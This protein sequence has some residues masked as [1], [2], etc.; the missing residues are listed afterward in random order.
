MRRPGRACSPVALG[1]TGSLGSLTHSIYPIATGWVQIDS[2]AITD[3]SGLG[4]RRAAPDR[5]CL[6]D[7]P[8]PGSSLR[9]C[10]RSSPQRV[11]QHQGAQSVTDTL[12]GG[13]SSPLQ[14]CP[15]SVQE[16]QRLPV[17]LVVI[18]EHRC[19]ESRSARPDHR[20]GMLVSRESPLAQS[21]DACSKLRR[22]TASAN[23]R[24]CRRRDCS[25]NP[26][27]T[28][29]M[30]P[31]TS[32]INSRSIPR[33]VRI[34]SQIFAIAPHLPPWPYWHP[35]RIRSA[36]GAGRSAHAGLSSSVTSAFGS[37]PTTHRSSSRERER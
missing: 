13:P 5:P 11:A 25:P 32:P 10:A 4:R 31:P 26:V 19:C 18:D 6:V 8:Q 15:G 21:C 12:I 29:K 27:H 35:R 23:R 36:L 28:T 14:T 7:T 3:Q 34:P 33:I 2:K 24:A 17:N 9:S 20:L 37:V 1:S 30:I 22:A 16:Q